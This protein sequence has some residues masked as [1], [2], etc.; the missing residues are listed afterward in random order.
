M[1][2]RMVDEDVV[3]L[4]PS[5]VYRILKSAKLVCPWRRRTK[6]RRG[7]EEVPAG[8]AKILSDQ[9]QFPHQGADP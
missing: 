7:E 3:Y 4:S 8:R 9:A 6:R 2:W 1:A 5:T